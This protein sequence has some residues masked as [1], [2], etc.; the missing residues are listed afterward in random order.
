MVEAMVDPRDADKE[1]FFR[2]MALHK[3]FLNADFMRDVF[4]RRVNREQTPAEVDFA[5]SMDDTIALSLWYATVYVV[6]EGWRDARLT[7]SE[8]DELLGDDRVEEL[9]RFRNQIFHYQPEYDNPKLLE[10]LGTGDADV[11][12]AINWIRRTHTALG[13]AIENAVQDL[14]DRR[15]AEG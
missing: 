6:V 4:I 1:Q 11:Q 10:F 2:V 5:T 8:V 9:R 7:D 13:R 15:R 3:Y 14:I 12:E